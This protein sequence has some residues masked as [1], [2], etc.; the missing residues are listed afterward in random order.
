M[1]LGFM[2]GRLSIMYNGKLKSFLLTL[3]SEFYIASSLN[4]NLIEW[5][6]DEENFDKNPIVTK[7]GN[8]E[9]KI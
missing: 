3:K 2:Q 9:I 1:N 6:I 5:T 4:I 7:K 8:S